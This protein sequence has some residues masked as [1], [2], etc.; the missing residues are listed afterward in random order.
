MKAPSP[1]KT[2]S[3]PMMNP[4]VPNSY[5]PKAELTRKIVPAISKIIEIANMKLMYS[6]SFLLIVYH[7]SQI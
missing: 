3:K 4:E 7:Q 1:V 6:L 5:T 2:M